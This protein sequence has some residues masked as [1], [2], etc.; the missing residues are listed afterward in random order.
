VVNC[1]NTETTMDI[2]Y[3]MQKKAECIIL[4]KNG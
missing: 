2:L 3:N 1:S 4:V